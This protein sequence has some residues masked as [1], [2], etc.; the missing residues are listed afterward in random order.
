VVVV[1][2][3]EVRMFCYLALL[4]NLVYKHISCMLH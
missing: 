2:G 1:Y 3:I 4:H